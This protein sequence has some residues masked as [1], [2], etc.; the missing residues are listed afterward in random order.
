MI[1]F[2]SHFSTY[3]VAAMMVS[4]FVALSLISL[5]TV[6]RFCKPL[7]FTE[8]TE[9]GDIFSSA[10]GVL[11]PSVRHKGKSLSI[12]AES[13]IGKVAGKVASFAILFI[14]VL[15][16]AGLSIAVVN[17]M[18]NS[19]W[20]TFTVFATMPIA[21]IMGIYMRKIRPG[22]IRGGEH[23]RRNSAGA[24]HGAGRNGGTTADAGV[25]AQLL[26]SGSIFLDFN[27]CLH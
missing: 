15:T 8:H 16:L 6:R 18:F 20:G 22:D 3:A 13:E 11:F 10:I 7:L 14:L 9:F 12:I 5:W 27:V 1:E 23:N 17:S 24:G 19:P 2:F 21:M 4:L 26:L 25:T